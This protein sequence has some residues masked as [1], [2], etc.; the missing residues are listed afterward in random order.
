MNAI[1]I[2]MMSPHNAVTMFE[3]KG[4]G[5]LDYVLHPGRSPPVMMSLL[6]SP[7]SRGR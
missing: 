4:R 3:C 7:V 6:N 5:D 1:L 2:G